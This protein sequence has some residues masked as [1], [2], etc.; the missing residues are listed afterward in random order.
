MLSEEFL[1]WGY[2]YLEQR[3]REAACYLL[4]PHLHG[5]FKAVLLFSTTRSAHVSLSAVDVLSSSEGGKRG[6]FVGWM[7]WKGELFIARMRASCS[8]HIS[9]PGMSATL[10][11]GG[12]KAIVPTQ[13]QRKKCI[14]L[15]P[16]QPL[17]SVYRVMQEVSLPLPLSTCLIHIFRLSVC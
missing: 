15:L 1:L 9:T 10:F 4:L 14:E 17:M 8:S 16:S 5:V 6:R 12:V 7:G 3:Q 13:S 11:G 2:I